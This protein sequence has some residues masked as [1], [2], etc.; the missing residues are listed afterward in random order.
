M[1]VFEFTRRIVAPYA[2]PCGD[3][4]HPCWAS[5]VVSMASGISFTA[6]ATLRLPFR[7]KLRR[8]HH[9]NPPALASGPHRNAFLPRRR[10][11]GPL[12]R[13]ER[14]ETR[15]GEFQSHFSTEIRAFCFSRYVR[16]LSRTAALSS[17]LGPIG[18]GR[19]RRRL[20]AMLASM[21]CST[22]A[23]IGIR[24]ARAARSTSNKIARR[25]LMRI[26]FM[27]ATQV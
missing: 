10:P 6:A 18:G 24:L 2:G 4:G 21:V 27:L 5:S 16:T 22:K 7:A 17:G 9:I 1:Y 20:L 26:A 19:T 25:K 14:R 12:K 11:S 3:S 23:R 13:S 8:N 15:V